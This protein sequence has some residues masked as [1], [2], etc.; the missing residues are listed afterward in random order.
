MPLALIIYLIFTGL[1]FIFLLLL[2]IELFQDVFFKKVPYVRSENQVIE[3]ALEVINPE[4]NQIIYDLGAGDGKFLRALT[5]KYSDIS[6]IG[7]EKSFLPYIISKIFP[8]KKFKIKFK[9][10]FKADLS[11]AD[12]IFAYLFPEYM[13]N[14]GP[15]LYS[16]MKP[17]AILVSSTFSIPDWQ[18][19][20]I[21]PLKTGKTKNWGKLYVYKK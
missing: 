21:I 9:N 12:F 1:L 8:N 18:P 7:F 20:E 6:A 17:G 15:K 11:S 19:L 2:F 16:E 3:N 13:K 4:K 10:F 5:K 14:L